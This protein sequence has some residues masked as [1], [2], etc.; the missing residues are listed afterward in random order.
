MNA[1]LYIYQEILLYNAESKICFNHDIRK[2]HVVN[3]TVL[4][5]FKIHVAWKELTLLLVG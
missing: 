1:S 5:F 3:C 2:I 4:L